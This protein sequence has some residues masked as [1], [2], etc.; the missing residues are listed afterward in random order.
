MLLPRDV[1]AR[2]AKNAVVEFPIDAADLW[3]IKM[4]PEPGYLS[5]VS[6]GF[7]PLSICAISFPTP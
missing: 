2:R 6:L 1:A 5:V 7:D 3:E 4:R